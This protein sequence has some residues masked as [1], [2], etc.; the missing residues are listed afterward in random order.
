MKKYVDNIWKEVHRNIP[1]LKVFLINAAITVILFGRGTGKTRGVSAGWVYD[2]AKKLPRSTGFVLSSSYTHLIDT[3]IPEL[4]QGWADLGL[5]QDVHYWLYTMPPKEMGIPAPYLVV[6][7]PKYFIFWI[8]GAVTKLV[9]LD[10]KALVNSKSFDY[11]CFFEGRKLNGDIARD[12]VMPTLRGGRANKLAD[13][14]VFGDLPEH[15]SILIESDLPRDVKG[16]WI[17]NYDKEVDKQTVKEIFSIQKYRMSLREQLKKVSKK[18][19]EPLLEK[20]NEC[21]ELMNEMRK[22]LVYVARASTLDNIHVLG[23]PALK[24]LR[25]SLSPQDW[26]VSVLN[27]AQEEVD[28]C[29]YPDLS[30]DKHGYDGIDYEWVDKTESARRDWRW[31]NDIKSGEPL[32]IVLDCNAVHNCITVSQFYSNK[33]YIIGYFYEVSEPGNPTDHTTVTDMVC[34][35]FEGSPIKEIN[36]IYNNT[37]IAGKNAGLKTKADD[38]AEVFQDSGYETNKLYLGQAMTHEDTY[39]EWKKLWTGQ[40]DFS[41]G[42]NLQ[43]CDKLYELCKDTPVKIIDSSINGT[44]IKK[45]K[46]SEKDPK[47]PPQDAT[48]G[49][50]SMDQILQY[51]LFHRV[52]KSRSAMA[53]K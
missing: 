34:K 43:T 16:R 8:N 22:E 12:D 27:N 15:H 44:Q 48:H 20:I 11:G 23:I 3:I 39:N 24:K 42:Y 46:S 26:D 33:R 17:L 10:R 18:A 9:S 45:D 14:R 13:G 41:F 29:F 38:V 2:R 51:D 35:Y 36:L 32:D 50:E 1:Q 49:P 7:N 21:D 28:N 19:A 47:T 52:N 6:D 31:H 5:E 4:Q 25:K 40:L 30:K 53:A 37:M